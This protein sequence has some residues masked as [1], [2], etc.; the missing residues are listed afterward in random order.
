[1][2]AVKLLDVAQLCPHIPF[3]LY[4]NSNLKRHLIIDQI[5]Y[6][7]QYGKFLI[8]ASGFRDGE[9]Y[10]IDETVYISDM[11]YKKYFK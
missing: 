7:K 5:P 1:M 4:E 3:S 9:G 6:A 11:H 8:K 10:S 2:K